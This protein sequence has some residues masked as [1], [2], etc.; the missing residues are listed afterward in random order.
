MAG[1]AAA[2]ALSATPAEPDP[3]IEPA[4]V[5]LPK[6]M[7]QTHGRAESMSYHSSEG[8]GRQVIRSS[9]CWAG[10]PPVA[11][12]AQQLDNQIT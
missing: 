9:S 2:T 10:S 3:M 7:V 1:L 12:V 5:E 8:A 6:R 11:D 4:A